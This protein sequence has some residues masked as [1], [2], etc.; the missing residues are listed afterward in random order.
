VT[1]RAVGQLCLPALS[2]A[3]PLVPVLLTTVRF[4]PAL[5]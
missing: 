2:R 1:Q 4:L 3:A 5:P